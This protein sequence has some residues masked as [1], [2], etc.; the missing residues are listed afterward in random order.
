MKQRDTEELMLAESLELGE[1]LLSKK[2]EIMAL[3]KRAYEKSSLTVAAGKGG[4]VIERM[5]QDVVTTTDKEVERIYIQ[6]VMGNRAKYPNVTIDSEDET[7]KMS[8]EGKVVL[9]LDPVDGSKHLLEGLGYVASCASISVKGRVV[10]AMVI[11]PI[12][13]DVF[14]ADRGGAY[15]NSKRIKNSNRSI[16]S[17]PNRY[18]FVFYESPTSKLKENEQKKFNRYVE[19]QTLLQRNAFRTRNIGIGSLQICYVAANKSS[20]YLDL[21]GSTK[22]YDVEAA[23]FIA[24]QAGLRI[25]T[26]EGKN[27]SKIAFNKDLDRKIINDSLLIGGL[28]ACR[29]VLGFI[30][31]R[32]IECEKLE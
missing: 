2:K 17:S 20:L 1:D 7:K 16:M 27:L 23:I 4:D 11:D 26:L 28:R 3:M 32:G 8:E 6:T 31:H 19:I 10:W 13:G 29:E 21:S 22:L 30:Y 24:K 5:V 9:R 15:L 14:H 12:M 18:N 25:M